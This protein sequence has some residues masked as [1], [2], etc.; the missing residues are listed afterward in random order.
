MK[1][2]LVIDG[3]GFIFRAFFGYPLVVN[4]H[5]QPINAVIGVCSMLFSI[6]SELEYDDCVIALD[7]G[8]KTFR[9]E[10]YSEYK[11]H[12]DAVPDELRSQFQL[13]REA[14][15]SF[16]VK[17][18]D[19]SGFEADDIIATQTKRYVLEGFNVC[20]VSSDKDLMQLISNNVYMFDP[21]KKKKIDSNGVFEKF[22]V[23]PHQII[24][25][26]ALLG[27]ASD[28][29]PGVDGVGVKTAATLLQ[30]YGSIDAI[31]ENIQNIAKRKVRESLLQNRDRLILAKKLVTLVDDVECCFDED[32][33]CLLDY[34]R[35]LHFCK[36]NGLARLAKTVESKAL[37]SRY[38]FKA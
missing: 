24:D 25:F 37:T 22:G 30:Q 36:I 29:V 15:Q 6:L 32:C 8:G 20:I 27:D 28:N 35:L 10:L 3:S 16:G 33:S 4:E 14:Y 17:I 1:L 31:Y 11:G 9:H 2:A 13:I 12:R 19:K 5:G 23:Y 34:R 21:M 18:A 38:C 7:H 26:L